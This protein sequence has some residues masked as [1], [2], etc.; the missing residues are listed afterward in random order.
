MML[1]QKVQESLQN[2]LL[3]D[4]KDVGQYITGNTP[5]MVAERLAI[6]NEGYYTRLL[7]VLRSDYKVLA[8]LLGDHKF[9]DM[10]LAYVSANPSRH[11]SAN[12]YGQY[13]EKFLATTE[14]YAKQPHLSELA[15][16][17]WALSGTVDAPDGSLLT[18]NQ[19]AAIPQDEW[20]NMILSLHPSVQLHQSDWNILPLWQAV[21]QDQKLPVVTKLDNKAYCVVWRK[22]MQPYYCSLSEEEAWVLQALQQ[23]QT[24]G[25]ICDGLL[26]WYPEEQ[27]ATNAVNLLLRWLNDEMLSEVRLKLMD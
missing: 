3:T 24:F 4:D 6:Y 10:G 17:I 26:K 9:E 11:F 16:F 12:V 22:Q 23:Q 1:L 27:V 25:E 21:I 8:K 15:G 13:M 5:E 14:P 20:F 18:T 7:E 19:V 2:H